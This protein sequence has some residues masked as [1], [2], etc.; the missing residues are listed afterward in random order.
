M[1]NLQEQLTNLKNKNF[2]FSNFKIDVGTSSTAPHSAHW[3]AKDPS[4]CVLAVEPN[5]ENV[6]GLRY[7]VNLKNN[8]THIRTSDSSILDGKNIVNNYNPDHFFLLENVAI[9]DVIVPENVDFYCTGKENTG[10]SSLYRPT[11]ELGIP[12]SHIEQVTVV[13][14]AYILDFIEF[15]INGHIMFV[16]TDT[17]GK[18]FEVVKSIGKYLPNVVALKCEYNVKNYYEIATNTTVDFYNFMTA[19]RFGLVKDTG[20]DFLFINNRFGSL[21]DLPEE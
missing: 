17:Q 6:S 20:Y 14:L 5:M 9:D 7:G 3:L 21:F 2:D 11:K 10:C 15:P 8:N 4:V 13:S 16:K 12:I 1:N 19:N 18:D